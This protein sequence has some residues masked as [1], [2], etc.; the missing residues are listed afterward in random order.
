MYKCATKYTISYIVPKQTHQKNI[1]KITYNFETNNS[2]FS[3][4][5]VTFS[6]C[7]IIIDKN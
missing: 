6:A 5:F 3:Y 4:Q 7:K 1:N 2:S